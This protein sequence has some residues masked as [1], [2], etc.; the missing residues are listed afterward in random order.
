MEPVA[1]SNGSVEEVYMRADN[2]HPSSNKRQADQFSSADISWLF[3]LPQYITSYFEKFHPTLPA[4][5]KPSIDLAT[6]REPLLQAIACIGSMY[7]APGQKYSTVL[8]ETGI[9]T[10]D[11][12]VCTA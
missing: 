6:T 2:L 11:S 4:L 10:L 7:H 12:Y 8:F 3:R 1:E 5:H 9:K